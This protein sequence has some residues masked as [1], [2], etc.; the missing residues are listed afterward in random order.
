MT[1][2][3]A[4][5][6]SEDLQIWRPRMA[7]SFMRKSAL[8]FRALKIAIFVSSIL[9]QLT[10]TEAFAV[11]IRV[12]QDVPSIS[13][14]ISLATE[15]DEIIVAP[16]DWPA[17]IDFMGK[18]ISLRSSEG[19]EVTHLVGNGS[20]SVVRFN[21][22][23]ISSAL[24]EGFTIRAGGGTLTPS[25]LRGG[26]VLI[27]NSAP[28]IRN[29]VIENNSAASGGGIHVEGP[30]PG[31][32]VLDSLI[33]TDNFAADSGGAIGLENSAE[34]SLVDCHIENNL[35]VVVSGAI[36]CEQSTLQ[37]S[38]TAFVGNASNLAVGGVWIYLGSEA[39]IDNCTFATN[40]APISGGAVVISDQARA[41]IENSV[42]HGNM[43][44]SSGGAILIDSGLTQESQV[45]RG[46]LFY[47]N[48][49]ANA[50]AHLAVSFNPISLLLEKCTFG[51][52]TANSAASISINNSGV[53]AI[54][55]DS[56]IVLAGSAGS[57]EAIPGSTLV[58][59]SCVEG[60]ASSS[61]NAIDSIDEDPLFTDLANGVYTLE[62]GSPCLNSGNPLLPFDGD[63][64]VTD[65]GALGLVPLPAPQFRR[66]DV[67]GSGSANI[68]DGIQILGWLFVPGSL[69]PLCEDSA[70]CNDDGA[71]NVS[72]AITLLDALFVSG[73]PLPIPYLE[74]GSDSTSDSLSCISDCF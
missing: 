23:E 17:P 65:M 52:P 46:C 33:L 28:T 6:L 55:L 42:F 47:D 18:N 16:G 30:T 59:Y 34:V 20:D 49:A 5:T 66:G 24:L 12:P 62:P 19:P 68:A 4:A 60:L 8:L 13:D 35:A 63:G 3:P 72:D 53:N 36:L 29:C 48:F 50:G 26:G 38:N 43:G 25:G 45:I 2:V 15:G 44:G 14:A 31:S 64:T 54:L 1:T 74:C 22:G 21:S 73:A 39:Q 32:V 58:S 67:D 51:L 11:D 10:S 27:L 9:F 57:I 69:A 41:T 37:V 7:G 61:V 71:L 70:D 56:S 40:N